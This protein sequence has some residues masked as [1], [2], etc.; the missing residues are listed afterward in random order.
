MCSSAVR[1]S[2]RLFCP[3]FCDV[4]RHQR[5]EYAVIEFD[6]CALSGDQCVLSLSVFHSISSLCSAFRVVSPQTLIFVEKE[7]EAVTDPC[8]CTMRKNKW[9]AQSQRTREERL[10]VKGH[11]VFV[12]V[13]LLF[14]TLLLLLFLHYKDV[15]AVGG[16]I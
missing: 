2:S 4:P 16:L 11:T 7:R 12:S 14:L 13:C 1:D 8:T 10:N 9:G 3:L 6:E 15:G 5:P